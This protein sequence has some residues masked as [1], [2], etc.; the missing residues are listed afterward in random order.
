MKT[1]LAKI[2]VGDLDFHQLDVLL[3][4]E[5]CRR[6]V[7]DLEMIK[8]NG[9]CGGL[10]VLN[11]NKKTAG[12]HESGIYDD[13][14]MMNGDADEVTAYPSRRNYAVTILYTKRWNVESEELRCNWPA[15]ITP[16]R[17]SK[18]VYITSWDTDSRHSIINSSGGFTANKK[19]E[20]KE[21]EQ[22]YRANRVW[23]TGFAMIPSFYVRLD[24]LKLTISPNVRSLNPLRLVPSCFEIFD[25][26][27]LSLSFHFV[28]K[29][30]IFKSFLVCLYRLCHLAI[31]C[32]DQH[33]HTLHHLESLLTISFDNLCLNN[34]DIFKKDL[35]Y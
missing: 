9:G 31:L 7:L 16:S 21:F 11:W 23:Q 15:T 13:G 28:F 3:L 24:N 33:A 12:K 1:N 20:E 22:R 8:I 17:T 10:G 34:L 5:L 30:V 25:L 14:S 35:E 6:S 26:E 2:L 29:S 32:L 4:M 27:H 19:R 18:S